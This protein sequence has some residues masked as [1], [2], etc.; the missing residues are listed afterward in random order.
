MIN[1]YKQKGFTLIEIAVVLVIVGLLVGSFI[2]T[3]ASRVDTTR[4]DDTKK[5]LEEIKQVLMAYAFT[6]TN[7]GVLALPCPDV[8]V[9]PDGVG[10]DG[11]GGFCTSSVGVLPWVDLGMGMEDSWGNRY[12]YWVDANF[13]ND[14]IGFTIGM[15]AAVPG[16]IDHS[17]Q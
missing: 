8:T 13:S 15:N 3:F 14:A 17:N 5:E 7:G 16:N 10:D 6:N 2:G 1:K 12:N 11:A 9:P 4:R